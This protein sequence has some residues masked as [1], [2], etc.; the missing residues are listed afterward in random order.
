MSADNGGRS[1]TSVPGG[2]EKGWHGWSTRQ[3]WMVMMLEY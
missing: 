2:G 1:W 3:N